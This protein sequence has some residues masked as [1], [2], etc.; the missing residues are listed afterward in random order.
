MPQNIYDDPDFFAGYSQ[1]RRSRE[2]LVGAP[3]WP[4]VRSMLPALAGLR[5]LDLGCGFGAF[6]RWAHEM[7]AAH[8]LGIDLSEKMLAQARAQAP[9]SGVTYRLGD[10]EQLALPDASFDLV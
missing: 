3:E 2:G 10:I 8:V 7:G 6:D 5:V 4:I 1:F 9:A